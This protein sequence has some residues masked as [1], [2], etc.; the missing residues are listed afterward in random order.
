MFKSSAVL[1]AMLAVVVLIKVQTQLSK[2]G[3]FLVGLYLLLLALAFNDYHPWH[4][5]SDTYAI[6]RV[7]GAP[8]GLAVAVLIPES[9]R[10]SLH[11]TASLLTLC[12]VANIA[13]L[14]G[15]GWAV[16]KGRQKVNT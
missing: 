9:N 12:I 10:T 16:M 14:Y 5:I 7:L 8:W 1:I 15:V 13:L 6:M 11:L 3:V 2:L 4:S